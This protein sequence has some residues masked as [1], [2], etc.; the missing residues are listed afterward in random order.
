MI[1]A[2]LL[3]GT[4]VRLPVGGTMLPPGGLLLSPI[5]LRPAHRA[6]AVPRVVLLPG[7]GPILLL[8][9]QP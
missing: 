5:L 7:N 1:T 2:A 6:L 8:G 4:V 9:C 3:P